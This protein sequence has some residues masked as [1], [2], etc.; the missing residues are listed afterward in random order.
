MP[1]KRYILD[2]N[3]FFNMQVES[4]FGSNPKQCIQSFSALAGAL[5]K[6]GIA[7]FYMPPRIVAEMETFIPLT[8][9]DMTMLLAVVQTKSP[10]IDAVH[11]PGTAFY[12]LVDEIRNRSYRG[13]TIAEEELIQA[14][15]EIPDTIKENRIEFQ[16]AVGKHVTTLRDRYRN[17]TR[18]KF[19]DSVAD[20]DLIVLA[21]ELNGTVV[22]ADEGV[23]I[24][25]RKFGALEIAPHALKSHLESL[26]PQA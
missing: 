22:S 2:T 23:L 1:M 25:A 13:L 10:A 20:L 24:W 17:A 14:V 26:L 16:K 11:F 7:E 12:E 19:L 18:V 3:F 21:L 5:Q 8:D 15:K 9:P 4:G 6:A